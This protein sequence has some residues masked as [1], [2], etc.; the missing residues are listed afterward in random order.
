VDLLPEILA[1]LEA[2]D[3]SDVIAGLAL[4]VSALSAVSSRRTSRRAVVLA[5]EALD[6][7]G[8]L[9]GARL[10]GGLVPFTV[11]VV[12]GGDPTVLDRVALGIESHSRSFEHYFVRLGIDPSV[13]RGVVGPSL[14]LNLTPFQSVEWLLPAFPNHFELPELRDRC[15]HIWVEAEDALERSVTSKATGI[16]THNSLWH[17][18]AIGSSHTTGHP[19]PSINL[20]SWSLLMADVPFLSKWMERFL[21]D[22]T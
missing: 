2:A 15:V 16:G 8:R 21:G 19:G 18:T 7:R 11:R 6:A 13:L 14:P 1:R 10:R 3:A 4:V 5:R 9:A 17:L 22:D 20:V 12:N